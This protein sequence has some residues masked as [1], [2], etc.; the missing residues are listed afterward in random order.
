METKIISVEGG[1]C[2]D[3][4][5]F[6]YPNPHSTD[7]S[8]THDAFTQCMDMPHTH[9]HTHTHMHTHAHFDACTLIIWASSARN[10][11]LDD[12]D[13]LERHDIRRYYPLNL[14]RILPLLRRPSHKPPDASARFEQII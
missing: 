2:S 4:L 13:Y 3:A 6:S 12:K 9:T 5:H 14:H 11:H 1:Q 10:N 8:C 7:P